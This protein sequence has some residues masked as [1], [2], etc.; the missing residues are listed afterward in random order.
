MR[1]ELIEQAHTLF[2]EVAPTGTEQRALTQMR[3]EMEAAGE[4]PRAIFIAIQGAIW[5]GVVYGN[6]PTLKPKGWTAVET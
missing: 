4:P 5:D 3:H 6:W 2:N 1:I